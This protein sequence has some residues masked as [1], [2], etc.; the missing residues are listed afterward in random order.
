VE[1]D[2]RKKNARCPV[3]WPPGAAP[4][5]L[6]GVAELRPLL[7]GGPE[8]KTRCFATAYSP[9]RMYKKLGAL[10]GPEA[11]RIFLLYAGSGS[12]A[13]T[14]ILLLRVRF[15]RAIDRVGFG[16]A[17]RS[18]PPEPLVHALPSGAGAV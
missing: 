18:C 2:R 14:E 9:L 11:V 15:Q 6:A 4:E 10:V 1:L 12:A 8:G 5:G 13:F 3:P 16:G 17:S 7:P